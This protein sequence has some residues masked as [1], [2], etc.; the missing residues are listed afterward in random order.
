VLQATRQPLDKASQTA[1]QTLSSAFVSVTRSPEIQQGELR[2][3]LRS[4][5]ELG[6]T[7]RGDRRLLDSG[8]GTQGV[9]RLLHDRVREVIAVD[10]EPSPAWHDETGLIFHAA[11]YALPLNRALWLRHRVEELLERMPPFRPPLSYNF[12]VAA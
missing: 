5:E 12:A 7:F 2:H 11:H 9:A 8:C 3:R 4:I 1:R 6:Y 10:V